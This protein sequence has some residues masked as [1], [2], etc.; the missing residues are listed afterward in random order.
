MIIEKIKSHI[1]GS[2]IKKQI[3]F[4]FLLSSIIPICVVGLFAII[5][6]RKQML[7]H[8]ETQLETEAI[9]VKSTLFD[10]TTS[11]RTNTQSIIE[12]QSFRN[13]FNTSY[14][15]DTKAA[16]D[17]INSQLETY[18][19]T[20]AAIK[21]INV[22]TDNPDIPSNG[23][24]YCL[25][26]GFT[27]EP[28]YLHM[29]AN[30]YTTWTSAPYVDRFGN[31][32]YELTLIEKFLTNDS[33]YST[34]LVTRLDSN[35]LRNRILVNNNIIMASIDQGR[36]FFSSESG[37]LW[38]YMPHYSEFKNQTYSYTGPVTIN[39]KE[40]MTSIKT[41]IPYQSIPYQSDNHMYVLVSAKNAYDNINQITILYSVILLF[42][43]LVP[44]GII[45]FFSNYFSMRIQT[46]KTA[47][48]QASLGD[49]NIIDTFRGDDEL[50]DTFNDLKTTVNYIHEKET[51]YY[52]AKLKEQ[53][54]LNSQQ[55]M[56][57]KM[58]AS[59]INPH[60]LYNT[61]E[62]IRMQAVAHGNRD[63]SNSINLLGKTMHYVLEN[64]GTE[65]TTI[66]KEI[67]HVISYLEI[68]RLRFGDR[69]N[70]KINV[71]P[72]LNL[73][74][75]H[76]LPLLLQPIVENSIVHGLEGVTQ[77]GHVEISFILEEPNL[78]VTIHD[79]GEGMDEET[80]Q[81]LKDRIY[82][83][84]LSTASSIGLRNINMRLTLMY[85]ED[86]GLEVDSKNSAG[87]TITLTLPLSKIIDKN[88]LFDLYL[89]RDKY[90]EQEL[91]YDE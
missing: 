11:V 24:I 28:W 48:H 89:M 30:T 37:W 27:K 47:M 17:L 60:F 5:N 65:S 16:Y 6:A 49:Y 79:N 13:L 25:P 42:A 35:S 4:I 61:L 23:H 3:T 72:Y 69:V 18:Y 20:S 64:T 55:Q 87:T 15:D 91:E 75:F 57:F 33:P 73:E 86:Y 10:I 83:K 78:Y 56:E 85:G 51:I 22:Y 80:L 53:K 84:N 62:T 70:Y 43:T 21:S 59:Q 74:Q 8:Y 71:P 19:S 45:L 31:T 50:S 26:D 14:S 68:Q 67:K 81:K 44:L 66:E 58:L 32:Q 12:N 63:V 88:D 82:Q 1:P 29:S 41:F 2:K 90:L 77:N 7:S 34:Y 54:I 52:Q 38:K 39:N 40:C 9:R 36:V 76:I 46:L